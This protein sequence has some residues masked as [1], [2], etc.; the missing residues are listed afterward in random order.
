MSGRK[1][2]P[3]RRAAA[4]RQAKLRYQNTPPEVRTQWLATGRAKWEAKYPHR[5]AFMAQLRADMAS[6]AV[7]PQPCDRCG[8]GGQPVIQWA[9]SAGIG[10]VTGWRCYPCRRAPP[11][12]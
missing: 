8:S 5:V 12:T 3:E 4:S 7:A 2:S 10:T 6:G 11:A 1:W 9:D